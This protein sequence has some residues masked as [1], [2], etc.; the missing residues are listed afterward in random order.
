VLAVFGVLGYVCR[1][2]AIP[3]APMVLAFVL[4]GVVERGLRAALIITAGDPVQLFS[5]A[6]ASALL[7]AAAAILAWP[8]ARR[9]L[10]RG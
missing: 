9:L 1:G 3:A 6:I 8:I 7:L 10:R 4:G 5:S 2:L